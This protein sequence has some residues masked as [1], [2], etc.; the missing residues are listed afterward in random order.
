MR[1]LATLT[2]LAL[3]FGCAPESSFHVD[4]DHTV[5]V[6]SS[7]DEAFAGPGFEAT[8]DDA[9]AEAAMARVEAPVLLV[10][11]A[12]EL[13]VVIDDVPELDFEQALPDD[14]DVSLPKSDMLTKRR[15]LA[16]AQLTSEALS[17][18]NQYVALHDSS[19]RVCR[20]LLGD[21]WL[22]ERIATESWG[23]GEDLEYREGPARTVVA[24]DLLGVEGDCTGATFA[25]R[26]D[27][28]GAH[29][30][31]LPAGTLSRS[32]KARALTAFTTLPLYERTQR[33]FEERDWLEES[34]PKPTGAWQ[35]YNGTADVTRFHHAAS[36]RSLIRVAASAGA[37]CGDFY[38]GLWA[39]WEETAAGLELRAVHEGERAATEIVE[40]DGRLAFVDSGVVAFADGA[41]LQ[42]VDVTSEVWHCPC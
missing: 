23:E 15:R 31:S 3:G 27:A 9:T 21:A 29:F 5:E 39:V 2:L 30:V 22:V 26:E 20:A 36:G 33:R 18:L 8:E 13:M 19:G 6:G 12:G 24:A 37:G 16:D 14:E 11:H 40:R 17:S 4:S 7:P 35:D 38:G 28:L 25:M 42:E 32:V 34:E 1:N 41:Q 10:V